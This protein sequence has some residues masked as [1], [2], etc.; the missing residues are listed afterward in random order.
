MKRTV[1]QI[2]MHNVLASALLFTLRRLLTYFT[3]TYIRLVWT[4][5]LSCSLQPG[6]LRAPALHS[7]QLRT[8]YLGWAG[9]VQ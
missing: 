5:R 7:G 8:I 2:T 6:D 3:G 1:I 4:V 9:H